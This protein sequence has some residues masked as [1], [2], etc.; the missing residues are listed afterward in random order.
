MK[1]I[2]IAI[3]ATILFSNSLVFAY[4]YEN[5]GS[6]LDDFDVRWAIN[7][8]IDLKESVDEITSELY[9]LDE[10]ERV[11]WK[12]SDK[13]RETRTEIVRVI[14]TINTT[15]QEVWSMLK[16]N[17]IY[18]KQIFL[19]QKELNE[20][21]NELN[22]TKQYLKDFTNFMYKLDNDLYGNTAEDID[23]LKLL[24][25][26]D[27]IPV[28]LAGD[29]L[30][31]SMVLQFNELVEKLQQKKNYLI[32][33]LQLYKNDRFRDQGTLDNIFNSVKDVYL[34]IKGFVGD[35]EWGDYKTTIDM[36]EKI[37][38]LRNTEKIAAKEDHPIA[39]P[40]YPVSYIHTYFDDNAFEDKY[41]V[42]HHGIQVAAVQWT[43][44][45]AARDGI[46]YHVVDNEWVGINWILI[47]HNK[48]YITSYIYMSNVIAKEWEVVRRWEIIWYS[49]G[50][51]GT[52][53]AWFISNWANLT[54]WVFKDGIA[55]DPLTILDLSIVKNKDILPDEYHI[56]YLKDKFAR[57]IDITEL[58]FM[59]WK[60]ELQRADRFLNTY[61][62]GQYQNILFREDA[63]KDTN[64][65]RD[66]VICIAFAESTLGNYLTTSNNIGNVWNDDSG[67]R[68]WYSSTLAGARAIAET[69]NNQYLGHYNTIKDLSRYGN[70]DGK[71]YASSS[72]NRQTNVLKCASQI[73]W[74][75][76][77]EDYPFRTG[78]NPE[79]GE[80]DE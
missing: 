27:N 46:V 67:N 37:K 41:G 42:P 59:E 45:Y 58:K 57:P 8:M 51:P 13:Y 54:F 61:A 38:E 53:G 28:T 23:E 60:N 74:Y 18:K 66:I 1:K 14:Q 55:L 76:I 31:K 40:I 75:Y 32:H 29:Y 73:K 11:D 39:W 20:T 24:L 12:I 52:R 47:A 22:Q 5:D 25:K 44:V 6:V 48:G 16:K 30:V 77:P 68:V 7:N 15:T 63:V 36:N 79:L 62:V 9:L 21:K 17:A 72:I 69:L 50:E 3:F 64:I 10:K 80:G 4:D 35:I 2:L 78:P 19:S 70:K 49:G 26:S 56:K 43:P 33:F 65:D 34:G 71:I